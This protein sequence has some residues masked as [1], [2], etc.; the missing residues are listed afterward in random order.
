MANLVIMS[1]AAANSTGSGKVETEQHEITRVMKTP[2]SVPH[3]G[4]VGGDKVGDGR[5]I[6]TR[7]ESLLARSG[8]THH[9]KGTELNPGSWVEVSITPA[10]SR[11]SKRG[12]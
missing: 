4:E 7:R 12:L 5:I 8:S 9:D 2:G 1:A 10:G 6:W 11:G 3:R